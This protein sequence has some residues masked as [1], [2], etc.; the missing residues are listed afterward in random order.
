[1][2]SHSDRDSRGTDEKYKDVLEKFRERAEKLT[3]ERANIITAGRDGEKHLFEATRDGVLI[4]QLP[5]DPLCIR[6]SIGKPYDIRV[7]AYCVYRGTESS[8][9]DLLRECLKALGE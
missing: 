4:R 6:V 1:M 8:V 9:K 5:D 3:E 2:A 7:G